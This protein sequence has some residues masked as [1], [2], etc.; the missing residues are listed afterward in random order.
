L[1]QVG[2]PRR[3]AGL[4]RDAVARFPRAV[5]LRRDL[6]AALNY[7][8]DATEEEILRAHAALGASLPPAAL[9]EPTDRDPARLLRVGFV[10]PD[11]REHSVASFLRPVLGAGGIVPVCYHC[12]AQA[13]A[14]TAALRGAVESAGGAWRDAAAVDNVTLVRTMRG[15]RLDIAIDLAG[16]TGGSR[17]FALAARVAPVQAN[18]LGYPDT[19]GVPAMDYRIVDALTDPPG[20][21]ALA[22]ERLVRMD[23]CFLCYA[24]SE[25]YP[26]PGPRQA[27]DGV[28]FGSFNKIHKITPT[29]V[30]LWA[31]AMRRIP[32]SRMLIKAAGLG[33][34]RVRGHLEQQFAAEG[35]GGERLELLERVESRAEHLG[36][37]GRI[38]VALDTFPY[39]GTTTTCEALW[40][41]VPVMSLVGAGHRSRVG[42]SLLSTGGLGDLAAVSEEAF[43]QAAAAL[44]QDRGQLAELRRVLR[45]RLRAS[46]L[47]DSAGFG[48]AFGDALREMW[49]RRIAT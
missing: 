17:L 14:T 35:V 8:D 10:S 2:E 22:T 47:C 41:G 13:D 39:H 28:V 32:G 7:T 49:R 12:S 26:E 38:D 21:D 44:A 23:P 42:L 20:S 11:F 29:T 4:L 36:L 3:A 46:P 24:P 33:S 9:I 43:G 19:T 30:R 5:W 40:M 37:Y 25:G 18:Y 16:W 1:G 15:D 48:A 31:G 27:R 45:E 34:A 6:C